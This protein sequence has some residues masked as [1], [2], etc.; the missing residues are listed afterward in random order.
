MKN[1]SELIVRDDQ[2]LRETIQIIDA[3]A[4]QVALVVN[5]A[6]KLLGIVTDG[7]VRRAILRGIGLDNR[8]SDVMNP[9]P[10]MALVSDDREQLLAQM[11]L[12]GLRHLPIIDQD[13]TLTGIEFIDTLLRPELHQNLVV[14]M[15]GGLGSRLKLLTENC[16]KPMLSVGDKPLLETIIE[17]FAAYGFRNFAI[18]VN[19]LADRIIDH[20]GDGSRLNVSIQYLQEETKLGT[21]GALSLLPQR[22]QEPL[23]VMNGDVLTK[24]NFSQL[25]AFH[26]DHDALATMC[27]REYDFQVP[28]GVIEMDH[29][30]IRDIREKPV[31][32]FFVNAGVYVLSPEAVAMIPSGCAYDMPS[33]FQ[34]LIANEKATAAFPIR[35]YWIDIGHLSDYE[36]AI[37]DYPK[38]F[39]S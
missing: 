22:P 32:R 21:A 28:Y 38:V 12:H 35:E 7:D 4:A 29:Y 31:H 19:Y 11:H 13:G 37:G 2:S 3:G 33:L 15:A 16:P 14:L 39:A 23:I 36:R 1:L 9:K 8:I 10:H 26:S 20:F 30:R 17:N 5:A 25:L 34:T 18:S 6:Y 24:V 27:V